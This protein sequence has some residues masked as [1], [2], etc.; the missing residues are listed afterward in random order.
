MV[1]QNPEH[2]ALFENFL[3]FKK[4]LLK[5][6]NKLAKLKLIIL[7]KYSISVKYFIF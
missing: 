4:L 3:N 2:C 6:T 5:I 7:E 1:E